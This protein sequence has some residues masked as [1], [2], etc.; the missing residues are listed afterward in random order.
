MPRLKS[1]DQHMTSANL[2]TPLRPAAGLH[3]IRADSSDHSDFFENSPSR[4]VRPPFVSRMFRASRRFLFAI[5]VGIGG[6]LGWQSYSDQGM[7][8]V[9]AKAPAL[10]EWLPASTTNRAAVP[11][12]S[13][14][15]APRQLRAGLAP[16][17]QQLT[18]IAPADA[19]E[20][21]QQLKPITGDL[22]ALRQTTEQLAANQEKL[23]QSIARLEVIDELINRRVSSLTLP[24]RVVNAPSPKP[25]QHR[26]QASAQAPSRPIRVAPP[27]GQ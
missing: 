17:D 4:T 10:A 27:L 8:L 25:V 5:L 9:R 16:A 19:A 26:T 2:D 23:A 3:V 18:P 14:A 21:Q 11:A 12:T 22:V 1:D 15:E 6:T 24:T 7:D 20:F 13:A